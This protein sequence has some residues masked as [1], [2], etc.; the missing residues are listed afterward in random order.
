MSK[1]FVD[2][3]HILNTIHSEYSQKLKEIK[4]YIKNKNYFE[5]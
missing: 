2:K 1:Y 5:I 4:E 3:L